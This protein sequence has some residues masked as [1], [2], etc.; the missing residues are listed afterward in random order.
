MHKCF[1]RYLEPNGT[2]LRLF[3]LLCWNCGF[4]FRSSRLT[5]VFQAVQ[6]STLR[7]ADKFAS[8][9]V[10]TQRSRMLAEVRGFANSRMQMKGQ[11]NIG[12]WRPVK[13]G[14]S[15]KM[16]TFYIPSRTSCVKGLRF[17]PP[18]GQQYETSHR[19]SADKGCACEF[20]E[21]LS[22]DLEQ[23]R[24]IIKVSRAHEVCFQ[25]SH[26]RVDNSAKLSYLTV[27]Q[28]DRSLTATVSLH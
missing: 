15:A 4:S 19:R 27:C 28:E 9:F 3:G 25:C 7:D 14:C 21:W 2:Y 22:S 23:T 10:L 26:K 17:I 1:W 13:L 20:F 11:H 24:T 6:S 12:H 18:S 5:F 16:T 8:S